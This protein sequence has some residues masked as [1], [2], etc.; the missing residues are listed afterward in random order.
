MFRDVLSV[1]GGLVTGF[2]L[3]SS[4]Q[5]LNYLLVPTPEGV[6]GLSALS[7]KQFV[8][9]M[10]FY[11]WLV[12]ILSY[13]I[14]SFAAGFVAGKL[15]ES[16]TLL[17]PVFIAIVFMLNWFVNIMVLPHPLWIGVIVF[18]LYLPCT[19]AGHKLAVSYR[20]SG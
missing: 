1:I 16:G 14:G 11:G 2:V 6:E 4:I 19:L 8:D 13:L 12:L 18:L 3:S 15:A 7:T 20:I 17:F 5:L 9:S 10:P